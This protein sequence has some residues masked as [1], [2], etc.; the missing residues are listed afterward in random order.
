MLQGKGTPKYCSEAKKKYRKEETVS[1][2]LS[3][4]K[5]LFLGDHSSYDPVALR[6]AANVWHTADVIIILRVVK[7]QMQINSWKRY[8]LR[9]P[10]V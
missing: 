2:H 6:D 3:K 8:I 4:M 1:L 7:C 9:I 5:K 10:L